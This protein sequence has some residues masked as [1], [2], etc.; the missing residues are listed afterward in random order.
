MNARVAALCVVAVA[1]C[2]SDPT[3]DAQHSAQASPQASAEPA[4][5]A[6]PLALAALKSPEGGPPPVPM[7][8]DVQLPT[9]SAGKDFSGYTVGVVLRLPDAPPVT[10]GAPVSAST[11][12]LVRKQNEPRFEIDLSS[13]RM[14]M[15]LVS[16]GFLLP[17]DSEIRARDDCYGHVFLTP[18][19]ASYRVLAPGS[20]RSLLGER[21]VDVSP[22]S[23]AE[24]TPNGDGPQRLGYHTRRADVQSRAGK[25]EFEIARVPELGE[26]GALLV[27]AL[28][29]LMNAPPQVTVVGTDELPVHAELHWSTRGALFF[30]VTSIVKRAEFPPQALAVPPSGAAF[31]T[32]ALPPIAGELRVD[33]KQL[34]ALHTGPIDLG[35]AAASVTSGALVLV[36]SAETPRFA[37]LDG[38]PVAWVGAGA[39][40]ELS[41]LPRGRYQVE[42]RNFLDDA[43]EPVKA[44]TVPLIAQP[45]DAGA[46]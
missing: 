23:P 28:L 39:R 24:V 32:G 2:K 25:A 26:G 46:R 34:A 40:L 41:S 8:G 13:S 35:P 20:L 3:H 38:A 12:D 19:L 45:A 6:M 44:L 43:G 14:S 16:S 7:R 29:D 37:W 10:S 42:W 18:D 5:L 36:N 27:R 31:T 15:R 4:P 33:P 1:A 11:V 17:R 22:L 9:D 30:E 21:R